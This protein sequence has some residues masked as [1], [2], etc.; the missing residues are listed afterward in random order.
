MSKAFHVVLFCSV[1][2]LPLLG[3][4]NANAATF[5]DFDGFCLTDR[6]GD[7]ADRN[8]IVVIQCLGLP[9]Q[10][11]KWEGLSIL[12]IGTSAGRTFKCVDVD[13]GITADGTPVQ[14]FDCNGTGAQQ[15]TYNNGRIVNV[16]SGKCLDV[17]D[18]SVLTQARIR[19]CNFALAATSQR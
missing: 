18:G 2:S 11:W 6:F 5:V 4:S 12:G 19:T 8:P 16:R 15:W 9:S 17:G 1:L 10:Q 13:G 3:S 14:L 7:I